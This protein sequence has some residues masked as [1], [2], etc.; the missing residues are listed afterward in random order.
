MSSEGAFAGTPITSRQNTTPP[1]ERPSQYPGAASK[2]APP[3]S[4]K[5][6][7]KT[8]PPRR[9]LI[10]LTI[11]GGTT[12]RREGFVLRAAS[13]AW[14]H[15]VREALTPVEEH[16]TARRSRVG[17]LSF[18]MMRDEDGRRRKFGARVWPQGRSVVHV[19]IEKL[20]HVRIDLAREVVQVQMKAGALWAM[21]YER[22][23][24]WLLGSLHCE[25][26]LA[27]K[28]T[29]RGLVALDA[30]GW[31][32]EHVEVCCDV[33]GLSWEHEDAANFTGGAKSGTVDGVTA[34]GDGR[35]VET[36]NIG[37]RSSP[38]SLCLYNKTRQIL[39][40][41][42]GDASHYEPAWLAAGWEGE[43]VQRIELRVNTH[44]LVME[45]KETGEVIDLRSPVALA[46]GR[47]LG[48]AWR[49]HFT[50]KRLTVEG[51]TRKERRKTDPRWEYVQRLGGVREGFDTGWRQARDVQRS[52]LL[53]IVERSSRRALRSLVQL[54]AA[55]G[56]CPDPKAYAQGGVVDEVK[57]R[58]VLLAQLL[59]TA[60]AVLRD[61]G[62]K[63]AVELAEYGSNYRKAYEHWL[64]PEF[65]LLAEHWPKEDRGA[66][67]GPLPR[68]SLLSSEFWSAWSAGG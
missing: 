19:H 63:A 62:P 60:A 48:E 64:G 16:E 13:P 5:A 58:Q 15:V 4:A 53:S 34:W 44:G 26:F 42:D 29:P 28:G 35:R 46:S 52:A 45:S 20:V 24:A 36:L 49:L 3:V 23:C 55:S 11:D 10:P 57:V 61:V 67:A 47:L 7:H 65:E 9:Q 38:V 22:A 18:V 33:L 17:A 12:L 1:T 39:D 41:K 59:E 43:E 40:A 2:A 30:C 68:V 31:R 25:L 51:A 21:G 6:S 56:R 14:D 66:I 37:R 8:P 54:T 32:V 50:K 27:G